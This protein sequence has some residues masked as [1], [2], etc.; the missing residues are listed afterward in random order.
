MDT[1]LELGGSE[2]VAIGELKKFD[3]MIMNSIP[4]CSEECFT[5]GDCVYR[6]DVRCGLRVN[7]LKVVMKG[8]EGYVK[9]IDSMEAMKISF[10]LI[11][12]F[13]QLV[14]MKLYLYD[15]G[16]N[17]VMLGNRIHPVYA[18]IRSVIREINFMLKE[19]GVGIRGKKE[20]LDDSLVLMNGD[21]G[22]YDKLIKRAC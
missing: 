3:I 10:L 9:E 11:P 8:L 18:E 17:G 4:M 1:N 2:I 13:L 12:L 15:L 7:Y 22:Y 6:G 5:Y 19:S 14:D 20:N 21:N 16:I